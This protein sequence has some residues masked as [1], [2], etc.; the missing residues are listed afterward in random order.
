MM[1]KCMG[2]S[3][4]TNERDSGSVVKTIPGNTQNTPG[5][6]IREPLGGSKVDT[7]TE[8]RHSAKKVEL[9]S[10]D[11]DDP[12]GWIS[13]AEVYFRV[14]GTSPEVKVELGQLCMEGHTIHFFNSLVGE[15]E[16]MTWESLKETLL[17]RYGGHGDVYEQL[18][19][20][21]QK[22][23]V[24]EYIIEFEYLTAKI[25]KLPEKQF[26]GYFI[27]ARAIEKE[28]KGF[29]GSGLHRGPRIGPH[30]PLQGDGEAMV[31]AVEVEEEEEEDEKGDISV[32]DL[33][34]IAHENHQ[35]M[36]FQDTAQMQVK[37]GNG[38]QIGA[39][40]RCKELEMHIGDFKIKQ[41]VHLL[42]LGGIDVVLGMK[43]LKTLGD[44]IINWKQ[45]TMSFWVDSK[46]ITLKSKGGCK[47]SNVA[48][49]S[50]LGKPKS[51]MEGVMWE[52]EG[53]KPRVVHEIIKPESPHLEM[54]GVL[55]EYANIFQT[56][57][58]LPPRRGKEHAI[59]LI[60]GQGVVSVRPY[61]YPH[62]HKNEIEK[63]VKEMLEV[64]IIRHSTSAFSSPHL[65]EV[66]ELL[67]VHSLAANK[68]KCN[69]AQK[70]V[71][72]L[73]H[74]ITGEVVA[75]DPNKVISVL[76]WP[77]PKNVKGVRGFLGL[78]WYYRK[79][80]KDYGK[81][82]KPLTELTKKDNFKWNEQAQL[83]FEVLK[84][85]LSSAP[86]LALP[87]F[88]KS[89]VIEC[90]AS[91]TGIHDN[92]DLTAMSSSVRW[93][94]EEEI[95]EEVNKD[96]KLQKIITDLQQDPMS[97]PGYSYKQGVLF[98]E[99]KLVISKNSGLIPIFLEE[100]HATPQGGHSSFYKTY[101]R[102]AA[103][104]YWVGMKSTIQEYV[105]QCDI[106]Q[107]QK[108]LASSPGGL[109]PNSIW[110]DISMDFITGLPKSKQFE[111]ILV[112][113]D[114]LS[115]YSH[116][117]PLKHPYIAK[118]VAE[119]FCKEVVRLHGIP[120][121]IVSDRDP[122]FMSSFW[123]E[124]FRMQGTKLKMSTSYHPETDGQTV[125]N[126]F[127]ATAVDP[128]NGSLGTIAPIAIGFIVG[129][130]ILAGGDFDG[131]S[132]SPAVSFGPAVVSWTWANQWV[133]WVGLLKNMLPLN[134]SSCVVVGL[135]FEALC[136]SVGFVVGSNKFGLANAM[137]TIGPTNI[138]GP[139]TATSR[140][141]R[142]PSLVEFLPSV[143]IEPRTLG[144]K[145]M[146]LNPRVRGSIPTEG[147]NSTREGG[148]EDRE[149]AVPGQPKLVG[150]GLLQI[151]LHF[152]LYW[153][154]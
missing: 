30:R 35:T 121:S 15:D 57:S 16:T 53:V 149:V 87:D 108:Y 112:V 122:I 75:V 56:P 70:S 65:R 78:T 13:R 61:Q 136:F 126:K 18:T 93:A 129:A 6:K 37:L 111:D 132:M 131:A 54:E 34:H 60:E 109:L 133:Y 81:I 140:S 66:L 58:S 51:K 142:P 38:V 63:Q 12:A 39:Q 85:K 114:R 98:Y 40:G 146:F 130:N 89:F 77:Q 19:E 22:G 83:A 95:R 43:W 153:L 117:I 103:N 67:R 99:N 76:Q 2:K 80:I 31:L 50:I 141:S 152:S 148:G 21:K 124:M 123:R 47:Q 154:F 92:V 150:P 145:Y 48:L 100:F 36:K 17:E 26:R 144:F 125:V 7:L 46:W 96:E 32:L 119:I 106:C 151:A 14:Q 20:M 68:K 91:G 127:Y 120:I 25:P 90:D 118:S 45:Q 116:F 44:T 105:R 71:E 29:S 97:W 143:E 27:H 110:E 8:F 104:I 41:D 137:A 139:G 84:A 69:F 86:V 102:I 9:P 128:N 55:D 52:I 82:T 64:G 79:F 94:Q 73:G 24:E 88:S 4:I 113:V 10:F 74:L 28:V 101:R 59:N 5:G 11:G 62:H 1:E 72:Y 33:H 115:K 134:C 107:R 147:K 3:T 42:E 23:T 138:G 135:F 49:Q